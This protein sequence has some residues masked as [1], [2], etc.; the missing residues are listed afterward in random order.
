MVK[1]EQIVAEVPDNFTGIAKWC[2]GTVSYF[3]N[4]DYHREDG[5]AFIGDNGYQEWQIKGKYHNLSGPARVWKDGKKEY[6]IDG[7]SF[8]KEAWEKEIAKL[9][10]P[11]KDVIVEVDGKKYKLTLIEE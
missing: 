1:L 4:G 3:K 9:N 5:P 10:N 11:C 6:W 7:E 2:N 8:T